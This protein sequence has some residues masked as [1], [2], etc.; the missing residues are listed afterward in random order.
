MLEHCLTNADRTLIVVMDGR[1][2]VVDRCSNGKLKRLHTV[3]AARA[4]GD[5]DHMGDA[6]RPRYHAG[7]RGTTASAARQIAQHAARR[8][9]I[10][11]AMSLV[12]AAAGRDEWIVV[13]GTLAM[14]Q[15]LHGALPAHMIRRAVVARHLQPRLPTVEI[16]RRSSAA[17]EPLRAE[18][19]AAAVHRLL[20]WTGAHTNG[21]VGIVA[22]LDAID[23]GAAEVLFLTR[24]FVTARALVAFQAVERAL[25]NRGRVARVGG[26]AAAR[27]D[28]EGDG[29]GAVLRFP[30]HAPPRAP[31]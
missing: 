8:R 2:V 5:A 9:L 26:E 10:R 17:L 31:A 13:G 3:R 19:D 30:L 4:R 27:L 12:V 7:T 24:T 16:I 6:P 25:A 28:T 1:G 22:T 11:E 14:A 23:H 20:E 18:S 15:A 29:I 21:V